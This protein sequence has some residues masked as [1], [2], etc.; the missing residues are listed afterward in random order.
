MSVLFGLTW[1][2]KA[3]H[4]HAKV[5]L[6]KEEADDREEVDKKDGQDGGQ[7]NGA[8]IPGHTLYYIEQS[9]LSDHQVKQLWREIDISESDNRF[10]VSLESCNIR[11]ICERFLTR[12]L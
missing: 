12:K 1:C 8:A 11:K 10:T 7:N 5:I 3:V 9:L 6:E 4:L 2:R